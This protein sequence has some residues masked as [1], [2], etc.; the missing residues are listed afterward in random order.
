MYSIQHYVIKFVSDLRRVGGL[1]R[2]NAITLT[3]HIDTIMVTH[4]VCICI[5]P[6]IA[7]CFLIISYETQTH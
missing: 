7:R 1:L 5:Q 2:V 6:T 4:S 3:L